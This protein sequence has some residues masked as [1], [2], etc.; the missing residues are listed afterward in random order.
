MAAGVSDRLWD[1]SDVVRLVEERAAIDAE[2]KLARK[3]ERD[4]AL[5]GPA[6]G[7][8][9][10]NGPTTASLPESQNPTGED[11]VKSDLGAYAFG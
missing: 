2:E 9:R 11:V 5:D 4:N 7:H 8:S 3:A 1:M 6:L 10:S